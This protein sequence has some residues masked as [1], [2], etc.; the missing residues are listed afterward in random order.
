VITTMTTEKI[1]LT[2]DEIIGLAV[3]GYDCG[4]QNAINVIK[5]LDINLNDKARGEVREAVIKKMGM[6]IEAREKPKEGDT[7]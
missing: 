1:E 3:W 7:G 6:I 4:F 2:R 5:S